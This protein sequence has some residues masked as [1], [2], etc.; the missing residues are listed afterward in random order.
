MAHLRAR[1]AMSKY[2]PLEYSI[3]SHT[4]YAITNQACQVPC[5]GDTVN[6]D[7]IIIPN[8]ATLNNISMLEISSDYKTIW[9]VPFDLLMMLS[10]VS[11]RDDDTYIQINRNMLFMN[12]VENNDI[13]MRAM[14][15]D[16]MR[17]TLVAGSTFE[18]RIMLLYKHYPN[19]MRTKITYDR[20]FM[21]INQYIS[22]QL[23]GLRTN[24]RYFTGQEIVMSPGL[25]V[26]VNSEL[27]GLNI[28]LDGND[29][30]NYDKY[31]IETYGT[32]IHRDIGWSRRHSMALNYSLN[33]VLPNE[34]ID[35]IENNC[36]K[37]SKEKY[38]YWV[39]F[40]PY[41]KWN[42]NDMSSTLCI[43]Q[44]GSVMLNLTTRKYGIIGN[45]HI[46]RANFLTVEKS[47]TSLAT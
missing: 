14:S 1:N 5:V 7:T 35:I 19:D 23:K 9:K 30:L 20:H 43:D 8:S 11:V 25:F 36:R 42:S 34:I 40:K 26:E 22:N 33:S 47:F 2:Y 13:P 3:E 39:P 46:V 16:K 21:P 27:L 4:N 38:V 45:V 29:L 44:Y 10:R 17:V 31:M 41:R 37:N 24:L 15:Y 28:E 12:G 32:V 18:Y 6:I